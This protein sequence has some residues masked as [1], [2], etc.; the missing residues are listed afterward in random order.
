MSTIGVLKMTLSAVSYAW[1]FISV[2]GGS[3]FGTGACHGRPADAAVSTFPQGLEILSAQP[4][5]N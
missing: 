5:Q 4:G 1:E 3:D 2:N